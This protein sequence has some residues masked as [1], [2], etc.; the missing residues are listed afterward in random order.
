MSKIAIFNGYNARPLTHPS[1]SNT[2]SRNANAEV[3][4]IRKCVSRV[5]SGQDRSVKAC[6]KDSRPRYNGTAPSQYQIA[7]APFH[8]NV[9]LAGGKPCKHGT[10]SRGKRK[11]QCRKRKLDAKK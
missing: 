10:V 7:T 11:G 2:S 9:P 3:E 4:Q 6:L 1:R 5:A 8:G